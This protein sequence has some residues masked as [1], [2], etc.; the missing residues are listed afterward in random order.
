V[1]PQYSC[2]LMVHY[3]GRKDTNK[4]SLVY[5]PASL[6][7]LPVL[8][9]HLPLKHNAH[10][11][12]AEKSVHTY[13]Q[14]PSMPMTKVPSPVRRKRIKVARDSSVSG[15]STTSHMNILV[16]CLD[17]HGQTRLLTLP[18]SES[19]QVS[20]HAESQTQNAEPNSDPSSPRAGNQ[21]G[22]S[23]PLSYPSSSCRSITHQQ[24]RS[25]LMRG[26]AAQRPP[27]RSTPA[28]Q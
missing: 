10:R 26:E 5:T 14:A 7:S 19:L 24:P 3:F 28:V 2:W 1:S 22:P 11:R 15:L 23:L 18:E 20:Q 17:P 27:G 9:S 8:R 21:Q 16:L 12:R 6:V 13:C 25:S 4:P